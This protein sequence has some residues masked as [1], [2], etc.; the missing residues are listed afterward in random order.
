MISALNFCVDRPVSP[1]SIVDLFPLPVIYCTTFAYLKK[2]KKKTG[3]ADGHIIKKKVLK[4][5]DVGL[6]TPCENDST[7]SFPMCRVKKAQYVF[8]VNPSN[9]SHGVSLNH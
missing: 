5:L 3:R 2:E 8:I 4:T 6:K 7:A 9:R 1:G